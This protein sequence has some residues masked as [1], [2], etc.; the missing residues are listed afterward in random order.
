MDESTDGI[1]AGFLRQQNSNARE[2]LEHLLHRAPLTMPSPSDMMHVH[3]TLFLLLQ[4]TFRS[5]FC[6]LQ[7]IICAALYAFETFGHM[8]LGNLL[9]LFR[10]LLLSNNDLGGCS[11]S[12]IVSI[13]AHLV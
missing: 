8:M 5:M 9:C 3:R 12:S 7:F 11:Y 2:H 6:P 1:H 10:P 4:F 13:L